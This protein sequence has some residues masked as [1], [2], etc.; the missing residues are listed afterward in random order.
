MILCYCAAPLFTF[1]APLLLDHIRGLPLLPLAL[2]RFTGLV[3]VFVEV[4]SHSVVHDDSILLKE[5]RKD[6]RLGVPCRRAL[7][8]PAIAGDAVREAELRLLKLPTDQRMREATVWQ[9]RGG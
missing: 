9:G 3:P 6:N 4:S 5:S 1:L 2:F 7:A 8:I